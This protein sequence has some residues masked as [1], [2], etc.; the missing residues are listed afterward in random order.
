MRIAAI[1]PGKNGRCVVV[2][3][4]HEMAWEH[5]FRWTDDGNL[6]L[7]GWF[8]FTTIVCPSII[9]IEQ[10]AGH[11]RSGGTT[12]WSPST[13]FKLG[14]V[15]GQIRAAAAMTGKPCRFVSPQKWQKHIHSGITGDTAKQKTETA[16]SKFYPSNPIPARNGC[17]PNHN[18]VD[19]L[20]IA[21]WACFELKMEINQWR[22]Q[23]I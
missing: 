19:A 17:K 15:F 6:D 9:F 5:K 4:G 7:G 3:A 18:T 12:R 23:R 22:F 16:Y 21:T 8:K 20:M 10:V 13:L 14:D 11:H 2:W 1:D